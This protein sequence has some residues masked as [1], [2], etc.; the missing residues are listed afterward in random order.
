MPKISVIVPV[1]KVEHFLD[2]CIRSIVEQ[3]LEE[4]EL[5][6]VN[7]GSPD[8][9]PMICDTW[10]EKDSRIKVVH[11][12]NGGISDA[13]NAG[14]DIATGEYIGFVDSDDYIRKDMYELLLN[15][16]D[17]TGADFIKSNYISFEEEEIPVYES[18]D[19]RI[20][21]FDT[22]EALENFMN[23]EWSSEKPMKSTIW[24]GLYKKELF[25]NIRFPKGKIN[26][27]TFI[28]PE[29]ILK[30]KKIVHINEAYYYYY[31]RPGSIVHS[32]INER[33]INSRD[34]W[35]HIGSV[36]ENLTNNYREKCCIN[37]VKRYLSILNRMYFSTF[38]NEYFNNVRKELL[39]YFRANKQYIND[40]RIKRTLKIIHCYPF[41][42]VLKKVWRKH[43]Y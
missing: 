31:K 17:S 33:E 5:I 26:E 23:Q 4:F 29:L 22:V 36:I 7:D 20:T 2:R 1:Y 30:A 24:D 25:S 15:I 27:D 34:L 21:I 6:L 9:C 13:R 3:T 10:A 38:K 8:N 43:Y 35:I 19:A 16:L 41:Y 14:L 11:K 37:S 18:A 40:M 42:L 39:E 12:T 32:D 28:F